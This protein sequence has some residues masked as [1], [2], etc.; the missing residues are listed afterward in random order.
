MGGTIEEGAYAAPVQEFYGVADVSE[1]G[2]VAAKLL[3]A[4][5]HGCNVA[6]LVIVSLLAEISVPGSGGLQG[7]Y[8]RRLL[9]V[10]DIL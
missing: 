1:R 6:G 2:G 7:C 5:N 3:D 4:G 8:R 9:E 10:R